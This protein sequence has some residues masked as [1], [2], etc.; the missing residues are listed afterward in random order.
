MCWVYIELMLNKR[1]F[2]GAI[3]FLLLVGE[4]TVGTKNGLFSPGGLIALLLLY[5]TYFLLFDGLVCFY[6]LSNFGIVLLNF[7]LYSVLITGLLH[8]ELGDYVIHPQND[9]ITTLIRLQ[10]SLYPV[11]A[12]WFLRAPK[13]QGPSLRSRAVIFAVFVGAISLVTPAYGIRKLVW[14]FQTAPAVAL[15]F[16][17][18]GLAAWQL[19][20]RQPARNSQRNLLLGFFSL[21]L[22]VI[23]VVPSLAFF[24]LLLILMIVFSVILLADKKFRMAGPI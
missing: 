10:C 12:Y 8:G 11:F 2:A 1:N 20:I 15:V 6:R 21:T 23:S 19:A 16:T 14:T 22:L 5:W 3:L 17:V 18:L 4:L 24:F 13:T 9:L 7:A